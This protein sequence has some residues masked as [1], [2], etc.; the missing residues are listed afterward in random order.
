MHA[1]R[2]ND[3]RNMK[4]WYRHELLRDDGAI[5]RIERKLGRVHQGLPESDTDR[6]S[7]VAAAMSYI[8][9]RKDKMRYASY[10][11]ANLA[12]GSGATEGTCGLMQKRV[13]RRGQSW[14]PDGLRGILTLCGLVQSGRWDTAWQPYAAKH[15][16]EVRCAA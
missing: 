15:R 10:Y 2:K 11:A 8:R 12:I 9:N 7:T 5:E 3:P 1:S 16:S 14:E 4:L 13:K 6:R